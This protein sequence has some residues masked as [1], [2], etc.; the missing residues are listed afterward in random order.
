MGKKVLKK[1]LVVTFC[2]IMIGSSAISAY[3]AS[4]SQKRSRCPRCNKFNASYGYDEQF[5]WTTVSVN[6]GNYCAP[7]GRVLKN[8]EN[9][10]Y[11]YSSDNYYFSCSS[12][13][14]SRLSVP[15]R[16]Y[17]LLYDNAVSEHYTN[18]VRDY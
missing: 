8:G 12:S 18:G 17:T 1:L 2:M 14:C 3:A 7:C 16:V 11:L 10:M 15:N 9:H 5:C 4:Y 13:N 6:S